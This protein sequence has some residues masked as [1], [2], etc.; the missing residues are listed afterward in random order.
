VLLLIA[1]AVYLGTVNVIL[2][3]LFVAL[4]LAMCGFQTYC[5]AYQECPYID[6]FCPAIAG[7]VPA[8]WLARWFYGRREVVK[9]K[10]AFEVQAVLAIGCWLGLILLPLWWIA[11]R[12]IPLAIGYVLFHAIYYILFGLTVCPA[13][14]IR[15]T[16]PGGKLQGLVRR[17]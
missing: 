16:C 3:V 9:S 8:S 1:V 5:C 10:M 15:G 6:G 17:E 12:S 4:Y 13:C 14:A 7:I 2:S 11:Q